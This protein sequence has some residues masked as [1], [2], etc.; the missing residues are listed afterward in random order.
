MTIKQGIVAGF[1]SAV[2]ATAPASAQTKKPAPKPKPAVSATTAAPKLATTVDSVSYSIGVNVGQGLRQQNLTNANLPA[3]MRGLEAALKS[4]PT[5]IAPEQAAAVIQAYFQKQYTA[6]GDA[7][8]K[9]GEQFLE[10]NKKKTGVT[11]T[12]S[13]LQYQIVKEGT[14][15][16]PTAADKV[17]THYTGRLID[18]TVFDSSVERGEPI[19]FPVTGVIPGWVEALQ[20]MPVGSKWKLFIPANLA[21]G[22]R[23]A[24]PQIGPNATL[25][26]DIELLDIVKQEGAKE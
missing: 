11:T 4:Q 8:K 21:Y 2:V 9:V 19:E 3:L 22:E 10:E 1:V 20:L 18:G 16:K 13:G 24:G 12:A 25:V 15:P 5:Q 17:K 14:G 26:F 6:K 7:N 23:G